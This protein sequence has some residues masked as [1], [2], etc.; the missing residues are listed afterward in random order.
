MSYYE[1]SGPSNARCIMIWTFRSVWY[2]CLM[3][4][5]CCPKQFRLCLDSCFGRFKT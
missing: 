2:W 1:Y 5:S 3:L 4:K